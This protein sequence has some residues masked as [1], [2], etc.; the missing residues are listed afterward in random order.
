MKKLAV[1]LATGVVGVAALLSG[2]ALDAYL[3]AKD[4]TLAHREGIFTLSNPGHVLLGAGIALVVVGLI[5]AAYTS[6]PFGFWARRV[7]LISSLALIVISGDAAGWAASV[8][9]STQGSGSTATTTT[10]HDH[11]TLPAVG[12]TGA[13]LQAAV[14]LIDETR[15][16]VAKYMDLKAAIKAGY[17]PME[18]PQFE[19]VHYV[20]SAYMNEADVLNP[21][22][23][24][25]LIYFNGKHGPVLIGAMYIMPAI[26]DKGPEIGGQLTQW[27]HHDNLCFDRKTGMVVAFAHDAFFD[28]G[29]LSG[30]CPA[31]SSNRSTPEMLHVWVIDNPDGP[32]GADMNPVVLETLK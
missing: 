15:A 22:H 11:T 1:F 7:F 23:V 29:G 18:P 26:G 24:Q 4:P 21:S 2:L 10:G 32:F 30:S 8:Q 5:G 31:G 27:H 13:Q 9:F 3:H 28:N 14:T 25:S 6:L 16:A 12:V 17:K 20:N 19:I